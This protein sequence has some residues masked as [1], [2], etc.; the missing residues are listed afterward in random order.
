MNWQESLCYGLA[1]RRET[2]V[3]CE[4]ERQPT[5]TVEGYRLRGKNWVYLCTGR[6]GNDTDVEDLLAVLVTSAIP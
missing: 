6:D 1:R 2:S 3:N 5:K 4:I